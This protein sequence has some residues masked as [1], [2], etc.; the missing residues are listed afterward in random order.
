MDAAVNQ[1]MEH[2][3]LQAAQQVEDQLDSQIHTMDNMGEDEVERLRRRRIAVRH[4]TCMGRAGPAPPRAGL[5]CTLTSPSRPATAPLWRWSQAVSPPVL[6]CEAACVVF[7]ERPDCGRVSDAEVCFTC[8]PC[9][10]AV[11]TG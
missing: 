7:L 3:I 2:A 4:L 9:P 11:S 5:Q 1:V 10:C 8:A 6:I